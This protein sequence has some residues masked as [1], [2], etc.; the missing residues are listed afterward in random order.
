VEDVEVEVLAGCPRLRHSLNRFGV[1][2]A[3]TLVE[4]AERHAH[5]SFPRHFQTIAI[6]SLESC[7]TPVSRQL[8]TGLRTSRRCTGRSATGGILL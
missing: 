7:G 8:L 6:D 5:N 4:P 1:F 2:Q 3:S